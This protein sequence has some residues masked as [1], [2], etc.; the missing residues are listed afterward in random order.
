MHRR[1]QQQKR[2]ARQGRLDI[3]AKVR[4]PQVVDI[5]PRRRL[6]NILDTAHSAH[7]IAWLAGPPGAGKTTLVSSYLESHERPCL[8]YQVDDGDDD[9]A[10]FFYYFSQALSVAAPRSRRPLPRLTP[11]D[12]PTLGVFARRYFQAALARFPQRCVWVF[13]NYQTLRADSPLHDLLREGLSALPA[14]VNVVFISRHDPPSAFARWQVHRQMSLLNAQILKLTLD[15]AAG[16]ARR[17]GD[18]PPQDESIRRIHELTD[19][20]VA[21]TVLLLE[22]EQR[23]SSPFGAIAPQML[24]DYFAGEIFRH[25]DTETR[26][27]LLESALLPTMTSTAVTRLTGEVKSASILADLARRNY[28]TVKRGEAKP[29]YQFHA[30][31][32]DFLLREL[33]GLYPIDRLQALQCRAAALLSSEGRIED[34]VALLG[35]ASAWVELTKLILDTAPSL[36]AQARIET[37]ARWIGLLPEDLISTD[38]W[39]LYWLAQSRLTT[40]PAEA[41]DFSEK[42][43]ALFEKNDDAL[44]LYLSWASVVSAHAADWLTFT[45]LDRWLAMFDALRQRHSTFPSP[46]AEARVTFCMLLILTNHPTGRLDTVLWLERAEALVQDLPDP[47]QRFLIGA[48][49]ALYYFYVG[50][51]KGTARVI[52]M[53]E[54]VHARHDVAPVADLPWRFVL[55]I[56][57]WAVTGKFEKALEITDEALHVAEITGVRAAELYILIQGVDASL[58]MGDMR[59]AKNYFTRL[60]GSDPASVHIFHHTAMLIALFEDRLDDALQHNQHVLGLL[61]KTGGRFQAAQAYLAHAWLLHE[62][63]SPA[64]ACEYL[65]RCRVIGRT[66]QSRLVEYLCHIVEAGVALSREELDTAGARLDA[67]FALDKEMGGILVPVQPGRQWARLYT[68]ALDCG[69]EVEHVRAMI[70]KRRLVP[71]S[72][73]IEIENWPWPY[74]FYTLGR[75]S[76][77]KDD[78][79]ILLSDKGQKKPLELLKSLIAFGGRD[80]DQQKLA[81]TLWPEAEGDAA[82]HAFETTLYRLRKLLGKDAP[83]LFK[84]GRLSLDA[85]RCW[86]DCWALERLLSKVDERLRDPLITEIE[87]LTTILF[88]L[89]RGPFLAQEVD[90]PSVLSLRERLRSQFLRTLEKCGRFYEREQDWPKV[91]DCHLQA[92]EVEPLAENCYQ[93]LMTAYHS[94]GRRAEG[95]A[96]YRRCK[97]TFHMLLG[98][99]PSSRTESLRRTLEATSF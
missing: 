52:G 21:G 16:I 31:F 22:S 81:E 28:F 26:R 19:G 79:A 64:Q 44:G 72:P 88:S 63:N 77:F 86:V 76:I 92:L 25:M 65:E 90:V 58:L 5:Y 50:E 37:L 47:N 14:N 68:F 39:V 41:R 7:R 61:D 34:A 30:L 18:V 83:L 89:Y 70:R 45:E 42:A 33:N 11:E 97:K 75:F 38:P 23:A 56:Y 59:G 55:A 10:S 95:L 85:R 1:N 49:L 78:N 13:D 71:D 20:W 15:E 24:F 51:M 73:P 66:T 80:V 60:K 6:F 98:V 94:L 29:A 12:L 87:P 93:T 57:Y 35:E 82:Q 53:L 27:I 2:I 91:I 43:F 84:D 40:R 96:V 67:A 17:L 54:P 4:P 9:L 62:L 36:A 46:E 8:W 99:S 3:S 48:P 32:R 74:R 69:I